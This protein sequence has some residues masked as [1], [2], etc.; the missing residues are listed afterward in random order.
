ML[1]RNLPLSLC[2]TKEFQIWVKTFANDYKPPNSINLIAQN[3]RTEAQ[4]AR[5]RV[6]NILVKA[7]K[8][9]INLELHC[10]PDELSGHSW[11]AIIA[12]VDHKRFLISVRDVNDQNNTTYKGS[13]ASNT[14]SVNH[15]H[16]DPGKVLTDFIDDCVR[17]VGSDRANSLILSGTNNGDSL[18]TLARKSLYTTHPSIVTYH[19]W[20]HYTN[21]LCSDIIEH[22]EIFRNVLRNSNSLINFINKRPP[23]QIGLEKFGP[24]AGLSSSLSPKKDD[25][26][27][28]SHLICYLLEYIKNNNVAIQ[29]ALEAYS[30]NIISNHRSSD[31]NN[32]SS[33]NSSQ[34][35]VIHQDS[36][37]STQQQQSQANVYQQDA[38]LLEI[39]SIIMSSDYWTNLNS[40]LTCLKPIRD[41]L[42]LTLTVPNPHINSLPDSPS[43]QTPAILSNVANSLSLSDYTAWFLAYGKILFENWHQ[44][45]EG[46]KYQLIGQYIKRFN[47]SLTDLKLLFAAY[48][49]NPKYR[50]AYMTQRAKDLAIEEI[51]NIASEF[52]PEESDGHTIFDQWKL[53]LVRE[54]PYDMV[55]DE[56]RSSPLEWWM[57]LPCAESIRRVALRILR[58]KA[59]TSPRPE[60]L[61]SQLYFY[62]D[63]TRSSLSKSTFEDLAVLRY[64]YDYEDKIVQA[65]T[66]NSLHNLTSNQN[67]LPSNGIYDRAQIG[68]VHNHHR[69]LSNDSTESLPAGPM[70]SANETNGQLANPVHLSTNETD[71]RSFSD[72]LSDVVVESYMNHNHRIDIEQRPDLS[73]VTNSLSLDNLPGYDQFKNVVDFN[74][75]GIRVIVEEPIEKKKRKWTAQEILSKC[76]SN[77]QQ[78]HH[79]HQ[80]NNN[81]NNNIAKG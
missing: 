36:T 6:S 69:Y 53:F 2:D 38:G 1:T 25:P 30:S 73:T 17:R 80:N 29:R 54:E 44:S 4:A 67:S 66:C 50:C 78:Q 20:W 55:Y 27:W 3:L 51:L 37:S 9:T 22:N 56:A 57:S 10:W 75:T 65:N 11:Y 26:R 64:F 24:F 52:M 19:C 49:L 79:H 48:L 43:Q 60:T 21:L 23:L 71:K 5:Q 41:I 35:Q 39:K 68:H 13:N 72:S 14:N 45:Q 8:K 18:V 42:A 74:E 28:Y 31:S 40:A 81:N 16:A 61:F 76:Q 34:R 77:L 59:F 32:N 70:L 47:S 62:E 12:G 33:E 7:P 15:S 63:E 46:Y 58:L